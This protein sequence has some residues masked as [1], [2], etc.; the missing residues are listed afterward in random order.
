[1]KSHSVSGDLQESRDGTFSVRSSSVGFSGHENSDLPEFLAPFANDSWY[2]DIYKFLHTGSP[3]SHVQLDKQLLRRFKTECLK[4]SL[5]ES[6]I[7]V[8]QLRSDL[9]ARCVLSADVPK[10]LHAAHN[11]H[12]HFAADSMLKILVPTVWW[13]FM[14]KD[15]QDFSTSCLTCFKFGP[16]LPRKGLRFSLVSSPFQL[17]GMDYIEVLRSS[18]GNKYIFHVIDY[19]TRFSRA[20]PCAEATS[21]TTISRLRTFFDSYITPIAIYHDGGSHFTSKKCSDFYLEQDIIAI[22]AP[23]GSSQ[24][25]GMI[26]R[27]NGLLQQVF[28]KFCNED[29]LNWDLHVTKASRALNT[30]VVVHGFSP[31]ELLFGSPARLLLERRDSLHEIFEKEKAKSLRRFSNLTSTE[32]DEMCADQAWLHSLKHEDI[33]DASSSTSLALWQRKTEAQPDVKREIHKGDLVWLWEDMKS[34]DKLSCRFRGPFLVTKCYDQRSF[35]LSTI[36]SSSPLPGRY[37]I[38]HLKVYRLPKT[39]A[40]S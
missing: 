9:W 29:D 3:P 2:S 31:I 37:P 10:V 21:E 34:K 19:F 35:Q 27:N 40:S 32:L 25:C 38:H 24:S 36:W 1:M 20:F 7:L 6:G 33:L 5:S 18:S 12:G 17:L 15:C 30:R 4:F 8:R 28:R 16:K 39:R 11:D 13:P 26:E 23:S 22:C 14:R